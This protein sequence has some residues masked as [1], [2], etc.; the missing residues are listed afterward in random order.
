MAFSVYSW[1]KRRFDFYRDLPLLC[2]FYRC[3]HSNGRDNVGAQGSSVSRA[4]NQERSSGV[5]VF[6]KMVSCG[7]LKSAHVIPDCFC[8]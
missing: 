3:A 7:L 8:L 5:F 6:P 4:S 2:F 1:R